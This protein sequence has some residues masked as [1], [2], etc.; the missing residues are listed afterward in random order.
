MNQ[1]PTI[2]TLG[3]MLLIGGECQCLPTHPTYP[4]GHVTRL[5]HGQVHTSTH[6]TV[7]EELWNVNYGESFG[8]L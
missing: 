7:N 4:H 5:S 3:L 8:W 1:S 2:F 6:L